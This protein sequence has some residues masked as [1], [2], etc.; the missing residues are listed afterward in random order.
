MKPNSEVYVIPFNQFGYIVSVTNEG[1]N[2][3]LPNGECWVVDSN[4]VRLVKSV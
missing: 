4:D 3:E 1:V 2:V